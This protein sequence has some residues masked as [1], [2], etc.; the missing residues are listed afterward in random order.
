M[1]YLVIGLLSLPILY[2]LNILN[3][4]STVISILFITIIS[5]DIICYILTLK[6]KRSIKNILLLAL[7]IRIIFLIIDIYFFRLP[8]AGQDD[9]GFYKY[10]MLMYSN[11]FTLNSYGGLYTAFIYLLSRFIG[12][13]RLGL[14]FTSV[15]CS[16]ISFIV[17]NHILSLNKINEKTSYKMLL[18]LCFLP[19]FIFLNSILRRESIMFMF[20][21]LSI[22]EFVKWINNRN[23]LFSL[24]SLFFAVVSSLFHSALIFSMLP[25]LIYFT[26]YNHD[27]KKVVFNGIGNIKIILLIFIVLF[28]GIFYIKNFNTKFGFID[29]MDSIYNKVNYTWGNSAYLTNYKVD[30]LK[31]L[32]L[33][34]PLKFI[35]FLFSPMPWNLRGIVDLFS[36][37]L[38]SMIYL[39]LF[40]ICIKRHKNAIGNCMFYSFL[41]TTLIFSIGTFTSGAAIR[42]RYSIIPLLA[43]SCVNSYDDRKKHQ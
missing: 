1:L 5:F 3:V 13:C 9:D 10:A 41:I 28:F 40:V 39:Y 31:G 26:L 25:F 29:G 24:L 35:Y 27:K 19:N 33:F 43:V 36:F 2:I 42:H 11:G 32:I 22:F 8:H 23:I 14:Q 15:V 4:D 17:I 18:I 16:M 20:T 6:C 34:A 30:S 12:T 21:I 37:L 7:L 38:D